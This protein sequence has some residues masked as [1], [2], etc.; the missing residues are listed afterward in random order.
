MLFDAQELNAVQQQAWDDYVAQ[1]DPRITEAILAYVEKLKD[2]SGDMVFNPWKD[3]DDAYDVHM[4]A[5]FRCQ[6]FM[7]YL[8]PRIGRANHMIVA[9]A[10]GYQGGRFTGI[11]ITCERMLL[12][13]HHAVSASA[14]APIQLWRTSNAESPNIA[15]GTQKDKGFNEPTDTVVWSAILEEGLNP[16]DTILW[17]IFPFHPHKSKDPLTNR[18]PSDAELQV[19][20]D[21][22]KALLGLHEHCAGLYQNGASYPLNTINDALNKTET[23]LGENVDDASTTAGSDLANKKI[24][25]NLPG[26]KSNP[27]FAVGRKCAQVLEQFGVP[28]LALRHPA[29]GGATEYRRNF[30]DAV[31]KTVK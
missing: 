11:A 9:E 26:T 14:V 2:F 6:N 10:V 21:Y 23:L 25:T 1:F 5:I 17:N 27:I 12:D 29:N 24:A 7:A 31:N 19:G 28:A 4:A 20:W 18:T 30:A 22:M 15:K 16:Y 3:E 13:H 8:L